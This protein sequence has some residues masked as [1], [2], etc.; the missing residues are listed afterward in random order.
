DD[1]PGF[2][3]ADGARAEDAVALAESGRGVALMRALVDELHFLA[4]AERGTIVQLTKRLALRP[5]A[6]WGVSR[7]GPPW[8]GHGPAIPAVG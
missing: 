2:D 3:G 8:A 6:P 7:P 5:D 1:G 4:G